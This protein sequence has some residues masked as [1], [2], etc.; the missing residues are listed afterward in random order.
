MSHVQSIGVQQVSL[1]YQY[2]V[3][4]DLRWNR[5]KGKPTECVYNSNVKAWK[6]IDLI[7]I[8]RAKLQIMRED[9]LS[10]K[11]L[12][13]KLRK[14]MDK[15]THGTEEERNRYEQQLNHVHAYGGIDGIMCVY[16]QRTREGLRRAEWKLYD[17]P[18]RD[19]WYSVLGIERKPE[20]PLIVRIPE[21][22][23]LISFL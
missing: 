4:Q 14:E 11:M 9:T 13:T 6:E 22:E 20:P 2:P 10:F 15:R 21:P 18:L 17:G 23:R 3:R 16:Q 7:A 12:L 8:E 19:Y 5:H 1:E